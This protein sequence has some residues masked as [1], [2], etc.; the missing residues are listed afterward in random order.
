MNKK[1]TTKTVSI[2]IVISIAMQLLTIYRTTSCIN[3]TVF[4]RK[5]LPYIH[6]THDFLCSLLNDQTN[7]DQQARIELSLFSS[8]LSKYKHR[9]RRLSLSSSLFTS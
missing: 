5:I 4:Y 8:L 6:K 1:A 2:T 9:R 3:R 7:I